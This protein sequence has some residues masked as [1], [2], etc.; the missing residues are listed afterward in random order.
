MKRVL[1]TA[2]LLFVCLQA[3]VQAL[4]NAAREKVARVL[5]KT[6]DPIELRRSLVFMGKEAIEPLF[7]VWLAEEVP[8][9]W[10]PDADY[11]LVL[12]ESQKRVVVSVF[13]ALPEEAVYGFLAELGRTET[14]RHVRIKAIKLL[15]EIG[16]PTTLRLL[17]SLATPVDAERTAINRT[18]RMAFGDALLRAMERDVVKV[19]H[20][21]DLFTDVV[22]GLL[23]TVVEV[24]SSVPGAESVRS[25]AALL[26]RQP[27]LDPLILSKIASRGRSSNPLEDEDLRMAVR[28]LL[29]SSDANVLASAARASGILEDEKAVEELVDLVA[30]GGDMVRRNAG[31]ALKRITGLGFGN[32][33]RWQIWYQAE[34]AWWQDDSPAVLLALETS[35]GVEFTRA[36]VT[37]LKRR[38]FR[39]RVAAS[40]VMRL[41]DADP[42]CVRLSCA[43]LA[44]LRAKFALSDL[45]ACLEH[46]DA[47][48]R[49]TAHMALGA[50]TGWDI[51]PQREKW[52]EALKR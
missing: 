1:P 19:V 16:D 22:P 34:I 43:A 13:N 26:G 45:I 52:A 12:N 20:L 9:E 41:R 7:E 30:Y 35:D 18:L 11:V 8:A 21:R 17:A 10:R 6:R 50:I 46:E 3:P 25:L 27:K 42:D 39:D 36:I 51:V 23:S 37:S 2:L 32:A 31:D 38:L 5:A 28:S 49:E 24:M 29:N 44:Q 48:V 4:D 15:G 47:R 33:E 40:L 14:E